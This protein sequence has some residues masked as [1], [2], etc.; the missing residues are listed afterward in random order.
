MPVEIDIAHV[1]RL[2]RIA[3]DAFSSCVEWH[4]AHMWFQF[5]LGPAQ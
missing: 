1:A 2:A 5:W 4:S 3:L